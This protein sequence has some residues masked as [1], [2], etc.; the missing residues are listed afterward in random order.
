VKG[1]RRDPERIE[2]RRLLRVAPLA[3][4]RVIEIGGGEGRLTRRLAGEARAIVSID[5]SAASI[6]RARRLW[7]KQLRNVR[8]AVGSGEALRV[9]RERFDVAVLSW[10]L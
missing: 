6:A 2:I 4:A 7:A 9:G 5:P 8:F 3:G 1:V 10:S